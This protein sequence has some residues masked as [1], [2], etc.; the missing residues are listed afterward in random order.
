MATHNQLG[1]KGELMAANYL[2]SK[3]YRILESNWRWQKAEVDLIAQS[4]NI[5]VFIEVK[6]RSSATFIKPEEA[7]HE[8]KQQLLIAAAEAYCEAKQLDLEI[9]FDVI[10]IVH[11]GNKTS[12]KQIEG[13]F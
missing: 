10:A 11:Q 9:R 5:L 8:K 2:R 13:A 12:I 6:T 1:A 3:N 4:N 7:V